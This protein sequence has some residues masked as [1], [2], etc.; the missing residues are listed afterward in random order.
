MARLEFY[1]F[2][3]LIAS[4]NLSFLETYRW[5]LIAQTLGGEAAS[6]IAFLLCLPICSGGH[7][8]ENPLALIALIIAYCLLDIA[9]H[10]L[11]I[12]YYLLIFCSVVPLF[13]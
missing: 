11:I 1:R 10:L 13:F 2:R 3:K 8:C 4:G 9:Y 5:K 7:G 6:H 12:A